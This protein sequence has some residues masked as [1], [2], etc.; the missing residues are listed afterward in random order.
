MRTKILFLLAILVL[1]TVL[2][3]CGPTTIVAEPQ[4]R[5]RTLTVTGSGMVTL[6]PDIAY[7]HIGVRSEDPRAS[8]AVSANNA[9]ASRVMDAIKRFGV[10]DR[11]ITTTN[12]SIYPQQ[13]YENGRVIGISYVVD[14]TVYVTVRDLDQLG[15]L[16]DA[17][18]QA[19][20]NSINGISFDVADRSDAVSQARRAAVIDARSQAD[21][22]A[23]AAGVSIGDVQVISYYDSV[24]YAVEYDRMAME[25]PS[26]SVP[27]SAGSLQIT[28]T[29]TIVYEI[30]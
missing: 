29:V 26:A 8:T 9:L 12:F 1:G 30:H 22:L 17:V 28:T 27:V 3:A 4:P 7:I 20:A 25:A 21:E 23:E 2:T 19:G 6:T 11:D 24:P 13:Q 16:L 10:E 14:N 18:V 15:D 5:Q